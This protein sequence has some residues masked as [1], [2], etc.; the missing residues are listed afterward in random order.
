M[1]HPADLD[2]R[3]PDERLRLRI[4]QSFGLNLLAHASDD[5][6]P[7]VETNK[8]AID[9]ES[10]RARRLIGKW[11]AT[12]G[13][14]RQHTNAPSCVRAITRP[15]WVACKLSPAGAACC[16]FYGHEREQPAHETDADVQRNPFDTDPQTLESASGP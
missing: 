10:A 13:A 12:S 15:S 3:I 7:P 9:K 2:R 14:V 11:T 6:A 1:E 5:S 4:R 16:S 8:S